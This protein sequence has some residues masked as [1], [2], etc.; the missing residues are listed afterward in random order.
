MLIY[1]S[2]VRGCN[3]DGAGHGFLKVG[4]KKGAEINRF[5]DRPLAP[6]P[7]NAGE[8]LNPESRD[9]KL[10]GRPTGDA[11][12]VAFSDSATEVVAQ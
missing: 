7:I 12:A 8:S 5:L 11:H 10:D 6:Q 4:W 3:V 2:D 9:A 1:S